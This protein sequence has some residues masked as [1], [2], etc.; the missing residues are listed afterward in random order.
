[1]QL[2]VFPERIIIYTENESNKIGDQIQETGFAKISN[3]TCYYAEISV[4]Y[5]Y[6]YSYNH[7]KAMN[8]KYQISNMMKASRRPFGGDACMWHVERILSL[9]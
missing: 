3:W 8:I 6:V 4:N 9:K 7:M 2:H 5:K 1:M